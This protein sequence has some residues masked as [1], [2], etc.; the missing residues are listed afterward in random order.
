MADIYI[1]FI[2]LMN[3]QCHRCH[4]TV[5]VHLH[6]PG[7]VFPEKARML[8]HCN[9]VILVRLHVSRDRVSIV[10]IVCALENKRLTL[11]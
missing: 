11:N 10:G 8:Q 3:G 1:C 7:L 9:Y 4:S 6:F 2:S 5:A